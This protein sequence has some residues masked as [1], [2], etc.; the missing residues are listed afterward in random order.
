M[1]AA[2]RALRRALGHAR[3]VHKLT[4][5]LTAAPV[6]GCGREMGAGDAR[7]AVTSQASRTA[8][9]HPRN[10]ASCARRG[11]HRP[12]AAPAFA[13]GYA[14]GDTGH[15]ELKRKL[16][17]LYRLVHP[18]L[19][20]D[21][22]VERATNETSLKALQQYLSEVGLGFGSSGAAQGGLGE[23][24]GALRVKFFLRE[25]DGGPD[26]GLRQVAASLPPPHRTLG[27]APAAPVARAL[28]KLLVAV[29]LIEGGAAHDPE[30]D[31]WRQDD[32]AAHAWSQGL[33]AELDGA[34]LPLAQ[35]VQEAAEVL[36]RQEAEMMGVR[37]RV[38]SMRAAFRF[39][40]GVS[41]THTAALSALPPSQQVDRMLDLARALDVI[42][43]YNIFPGEQPL[44]G[45]RICLGRA[46]AIDSFGTVWLD[47][48]SPVEEWI[49]HLAKMDLAGV[50]AQQQRVADVRALENRCADAL[51]VAVLYATHADTLTPAYWNHLTA[52]HSYCQ[53]HGA[54]AGA[55]LLSLP[56]I[57]LEMHPADPA[58]PHEDQLTVDA[59]SGALVAPIGCPPDLL[60]EHARRAG[61]E[62]VA[63]AQRVRGEAERR[64]NLA[65]QTRLALGLRRLAQDPALPNT[66]FMECCHRLMEHKRK[67]Q[68][69]LAGQS[70]RVAPESRAP[71]PDSPYIDIAYDIVIP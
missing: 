7:S 45:T 24:T 23:S 36:R 6:C 69:V 61:A 58:A 26:A 28:R 46:T 55:P 20:H 39:G 65:D 59:A 15:A 48:R 42:D 67:L 38:G 11:P 33:A 4:D 32:D 1:T 60:V 37:A 29:G 64:A 18:D 47:V 49:A 3:A 43:E 57:P 12:P 70:L 40:R 17:G 9:D 68:P 13:R 22:P 63:V 19:F 34:D 30:R 71:R 54:H 41:V 66:L 35:F 25:P 56:A 62:A 52:L 2:R 8:H 14:A 44:A 27:G 10:A 50:R 16:R 51:G 5:G 31:A 21:S 53:A